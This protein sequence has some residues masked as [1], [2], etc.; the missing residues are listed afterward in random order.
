MRTKF[1]EIHHQF[2]REQ[3]QKKK[4]EVVY[5]STENQLVENFT[6]ALSKEILQDI[7]EMRGV[8]ENKMAIK[9][10]C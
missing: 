10:G 8:K 9:G 6:K 4:N 2:I 3:V 1:I 7:K 5:H